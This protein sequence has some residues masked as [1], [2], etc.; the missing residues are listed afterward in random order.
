MSDV[1]SLK[2]FVQIK[3]VLKYA[4]GK[5]NPALAKTIEELDILERHK[6]VDRGQGVKE[7]FLIPDSK[8]PNRILLFCSET[9]FKTLSKSQKWDGD[10]TFF[11]AARFF[12][13]LYVINAFFSSKPFDKNKMDKPWVQGTL[14]VAWAFMKRRRAKDYNAIFSALKKEAKI[15]GLEL[16]P[17]FFMVDFEIA[18]MISFKRYLSMAIIKGCLFHFSQSLFNNL[19]K[20]HLKA[21]YLECESL[22]IWFKKLFTLALLTKLIVEERFTSLLDEM[23]TVLSQ[24][25]R[26]GENC[27]NYCK[28]VLDTYFEVQ[29]DQ[30]LWNHYDTNIYGC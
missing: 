20:H 30:E 7:K 14:P 27:N 28:Y 12:A 18:A 25:P 5:N 29:F 24:D 6:F 10:G 13:Q 9:G 26:I 23:Q 15:Y 3:H 22:Q 1:E 4:R 16:K 17:E 19:T 2:D 11:C 21:A 8:K